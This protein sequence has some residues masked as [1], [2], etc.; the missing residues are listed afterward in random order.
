MKIALFSSDFSSFDQFDYILSIF[1]VWGYILGIKNLGIWEDLVTMVTYMQIS[2]TSIFSQ[3]QKVKNILLKK[4][5]LDS[6]NINCIILF[7]H[8]LALFSK[9]RQP[10]LSTS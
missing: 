2:R 3:H 10:H 4:V 6:R 5:L 1:I 9:Y 8:V 7:G